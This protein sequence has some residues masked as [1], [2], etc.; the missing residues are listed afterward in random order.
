MCK[1]SPARGNQ[2][3]QHRLLLLPCKERCLAVSLESGSLSL[4]SASTSTP[5][6]ANDYNKIEIQK[7]CGRDDIHFIQLKNI[8]QEEFQKD[9][10]V[11]L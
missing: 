7:Q 1:V 5:V 10:K 4:D 8:H 6:Q 9:M 11:D 2:T 3:V